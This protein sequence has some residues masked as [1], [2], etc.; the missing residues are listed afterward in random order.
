MR[1]EQPERRQP[2]Q[3]ESGQETAREPAQEPAPRQEAAPEQTTLQE[4]D[5]PGR[6][7]SDEEDDGDLVRSTGSNLHG[8]ELDDALEEAGLTKS[9]RV[10]EKQARLAE[11]RASRSG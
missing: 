4:E 10:A 1:Q 3:Q 2:A 11:Y 9:G 6:H 5:P 7:A 8:E